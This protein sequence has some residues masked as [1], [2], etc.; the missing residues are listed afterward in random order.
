MNSILINL[1]MLAKYIGVPIE[2][3]LNLCGISSFVC[4]CIANT[5]M[6]IIVVMLSLSFYANSEIPLNK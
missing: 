3:D 4:G 6:L 2:G 5:C 1:V